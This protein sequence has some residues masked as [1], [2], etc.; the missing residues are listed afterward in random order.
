MVDREP[1]SRRQGASLLTSAYFFVYSVLAASLGA[2]I[3]GAFY[4]LGRLIG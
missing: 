3:G 1:R 4:L 2:A